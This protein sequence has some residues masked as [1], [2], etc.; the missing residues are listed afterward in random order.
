MRRAWILILGLTSGLVASCFDAPSAAVMFSC[1]P[2]SAPAC[3]DGYTCEADGCCHRNGTDVS[4]HAGECKT[5]GTDGGTDATSLVTTDSS[6]T[7]TGSSSGTSTDTGSSGSDTTGT[8]STDATSTDAT[9][10]GDD[11]SSSGAG[12]SDTGSSSTN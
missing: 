6:G 1:D 7:D 8:T 10:T 9:S 4:E 5:I 11:A 3:P 2:A 12:S